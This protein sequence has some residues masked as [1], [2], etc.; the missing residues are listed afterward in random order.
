MTNIVRWVL[1]AVTVLF[2]CALIASLLGGEAKADGIVFSPPITYAAAM[3]SV[4]IKHRLR[5]EE[6]RAI[7]ASPLC[8]ATANAEWTKALA[9]A[10]AS[11]VGTPE[12][13]R[14]AEQEI[15]SAD[16]RVR[17]AGRLQR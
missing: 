14:I 3:R 4:A 5:I 8:F 15:R 7:Q 13:W 17:E 6:C 2:G 16:A 1:A 10:K 11:K 12:A 9:L